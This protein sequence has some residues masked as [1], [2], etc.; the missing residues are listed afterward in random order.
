LD[1]TLTVFRGNVEKYI[2]LAKQMAENHLRNPYLIERTL[3]AVEN[4][5][6]LFTPSK[7]PVDKT[8]QTRLEAFLSNE[9]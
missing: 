6:D 3:S 5:V 2:D 8:V 7:K 1:L 4:V 9:P